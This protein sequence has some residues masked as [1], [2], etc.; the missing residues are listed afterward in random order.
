MKTRFLITAAAMV[1][2]AV[3]GHAQPRG[4]TL[5][6]VPTTSVKSQELGVL[7]PQ[8]SDGLEAIV[9]KNMEPPAAQP[10]PVP[11]SSDVTVQAPTQTLLKVAPPVQNAAPEQSTGWFSGSAVLLMILAVQALVLFLVYINIRA[12]AAA[13][14]KSADIARDTL[15]RLERPYV[16][17]K[18][19]DI[20]RMLDQQ[21]YFAITLTNQGKMPAIVG[22]SQIDFFIRDAIPA[23]F[24]ANKDTSVMHYM[25]A[26]GESTVL[27]FPNP[28]SPQ[29]T[30]RILSGAAKLYFV[31]TIAYRNVFGENTYVTGSCKLFKPEHNSFAI[32]GGANHNY[33]T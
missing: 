30:S 27:H 13:A 28:F 31:A 1:F 8:P 5:Q 32:A 7:T 15:T 2:Y 9:N 26:A 29:D 12:S 25:I 33:L 24:P 16:F 20:S 19:I 11:A 17:F 10:Q 22:A 3:S 14:K 4:A 18:H 23:P 21:P 6:A